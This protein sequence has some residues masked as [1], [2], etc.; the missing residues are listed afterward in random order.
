MF[1]YDLSS[2]FLSK[3][4][5]LKRALLQVLI[6]I[7]SGA[8][9]FTPLFHVVSVLST[10]VRCEHYVSMVILAPLLCLN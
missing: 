8:A 10:L 5:L 9:V 1:S 2:L 6:I 3:A 7:V 4:V